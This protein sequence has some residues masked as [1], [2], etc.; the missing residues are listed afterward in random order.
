MFGPT[1]H[2]AASWCRKGALAEGANRHLWGSSFGDNGAGLWLL[3]CS[4][5]RKQQEPP[6]HW[7]EELPRAEGPCLKTDRAAGSGAGHLGYNSL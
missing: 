5:G 4:H 1:H 7:W 6:P 2:G 3:L